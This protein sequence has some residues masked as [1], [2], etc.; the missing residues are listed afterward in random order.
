MDEMGFAE[1]LVMGSSDI[2]NNVLNEMSVKED[3]FEAI[4]GAV[5]LDSGWDVS[6]IQAAV[7]AMLLL[8]D[9]IEND[10]DD[11]YVR[12]IQDWEMEA[13]NVIPWFWFKE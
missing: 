3:L 11:N 5:A 6:V 12:M 9:F 10:C 7:E 13:N 8:E 2:K 4:V 1:H